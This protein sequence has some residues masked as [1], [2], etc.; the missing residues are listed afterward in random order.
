MKNHLLSSLCVILFCG[1]TG[2]LAVSPLH[3]ESTMSGRPPLAQEFGSKPGAYD[4]AIRVSQPIVDPGG[5]LQVEV[6]IS[7]YGVIQ[8]AKV[9]YYPSPEVVDYDKSKMIFGP[10]RYD[11]HNGGWGGDTVQ[12]SDPSYSTGGVATLSG[13][14]AQ[15][16]NPQWQNQTW[17]FDGKEN[18]VLNYQISTEVKD[19]RGTSPLYL[20]LA[21]SRS[22]KPGPQSIQ[23]VLTYFDGQTWKTASKNADFTIRNI[24][25]RHEIFIA[26]VGL[27]AAAVT[28]GAPLWPVL[29][30]HWPISVGLAVLG[31]LAARAGK[32]M[33]ARR[34]SSRAK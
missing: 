33:S 13:G 2:M 15:P 18:Q 14:M 34:K 1:H 3:G 11:D 7:G 24:Y 25:Q 22:A 16:N 26:V 29:R 27:V 10:K 19:P 21:V 32:T 31:T 6:Y 30:R 9:A 12:L 20:D 5:S 23:F 17:F 8:A 28:I 4:L